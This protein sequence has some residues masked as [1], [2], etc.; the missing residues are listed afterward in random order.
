MAKYGNRNS[1]VRETTNVIYREAI[2]PFVHPDNL[3]DSKWC[4]DLQDR[5]NDLSIDPKIQMI[6]NQV[7]NEFETNYN[8]KR[9]S[10]NE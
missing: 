6:W 4:N 3:G 1:N 10:T 9:I 8:Q 2:F 7:L 5:L